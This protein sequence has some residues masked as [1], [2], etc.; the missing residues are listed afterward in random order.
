MAAAP[1][2]DAYIEQSS[3]F[4]RPILTKLRELIHTASPDIEEAI[5][6]RQPCYQANGL[7]CATAAFKQHINFAFFQ[8][9]HINDSANI[10]NHSNNEDMTALKITQLSDL[11]SDE[12]IIDYIQQA[13][14]FNQQGKAKK[15]KKKI[16]KKD[17]AELIIP[18]VLSQA[19]AQHPVAKAQFDNFSY[20]KQKDYIE[21]IDSAKRDATKQNRLATAIE[22]I[23]EG[24]GRNWKYEKC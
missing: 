5:K 13:V 19:L 2:I 9:K 14:R 21:W 3:D 8:G 7:V 17:K 10:F 20:S 12:V 16:T 18:D 23:S 11:P 4:A 22:W 1:N 24:K 6:W 15:A